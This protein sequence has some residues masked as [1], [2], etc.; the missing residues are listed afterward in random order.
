MTTTPLGVIPLLGGVVMA[1]T[2][3]STK[4]LP[5]AML[6]RPWVFDEAF[7][8]LV[9]FLAL[10]RRTIIV[11]WLLLVKSELLRYRGATKLGN[12]DTLQ[13]LY[14]VVGVSCV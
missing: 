12:E 1:L 7:V 3:P 9:L 2:L 14:R 8:A 10:R 13:S 4:N 5:R 11:T 6:Y